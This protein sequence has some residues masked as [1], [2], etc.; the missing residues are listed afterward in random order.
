MQQEDGLPRVYSLP[1][2]FD[3]VLG[4]IDGLETEGFEA[5]VLA[6]IKAAREATEALS[7]VLKE[8]YARMAAYEE[9]LRWIVDMYDP[10]R[11]DERAEVIMMM[12]TKAQH[13]LEWKP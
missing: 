1:E 4:K 2:L 6:G 9:A 7:A 10:G 11:S 5:N 12:Q 13:A 8:D 3:E